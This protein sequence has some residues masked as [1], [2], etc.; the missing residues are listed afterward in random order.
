M[1]LYQYYNKPKQL[2]GYQKAIITIPQVAYMHAL[3][4]I[5]GPFPTGED[6][7]RKDP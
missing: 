1:N 6:T 3:Y 7:I 5:K 2:H 4:I